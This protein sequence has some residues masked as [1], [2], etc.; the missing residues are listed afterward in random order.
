VADILHFMV[1]EVV[2]LVDEIYVKKEVNH[3]L[4]C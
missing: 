4:F 1:N 2:K 3:I